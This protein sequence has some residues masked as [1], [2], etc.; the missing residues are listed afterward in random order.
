MI[1]IAFASESVKGGVCTKVIIN[2]YMLTNLFS[3]LFFK[4]NI[5]APYFLIFGVLVFICCYSSNRKYGYT[6]A[7]SRNRFYRTQVQILYAEK[8]LGAD[9]D[10]NIRQKLNE[11]IINASKEAHKDIVGDYINYGNSALK[12]LSKNNK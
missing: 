7:W 1:I 2:V 9:I 4:W 5:V 11:L 12:W 10:D 8:Q 6:R 3:V